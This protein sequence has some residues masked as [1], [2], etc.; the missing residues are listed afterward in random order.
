[1]RPCSLL[2]LATAV[3]PYVIEQADAKATCPA[4]VRPQEGLFDRLSGVFDNAG[5]A[6]RHM[7]A[8][9]EWYV[10]RTAGMTATQSIWNAAEQLFVEAAT[11]AID[12]AGLAP[13]QIDGV[14]T[15][16]T[17][18]IATPSLEARVASR[19]GFR[20][21]IRRVPVFGLGCAGGVN[22]LVARRSPRS[23]RS[24]QPLAV[25]HRRDLLD[26]DPPRQRRSGGRRRHRFVRRRRRGRGR[27]QRRAQ[28]R[29]DRRI[30]RKAVSRHA[31]DHGLGCRGPG[32]RSGVRPRDP[33]VHREPS[34]G[35]GRRDVRADSASRR[36]GNRP[37]LLPSRRREG[38]RRDRGRARRSTRASSTSSAKC[39]ATSAT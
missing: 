9:L 16:S 12:K 27:H 3:P 24:R 26:L 6:R 21:D 8:P 22:G 5:I 4:S 39:C 19:V 31:A 20:D 14:V 37:L 34:R 2:S 1:M 18:G 23:R 35:D 28:P 33:A 17:T 32:P 25:R 10:G 30:G 13:D 36:D 7:V 11:A 29:A 15:V 38:D